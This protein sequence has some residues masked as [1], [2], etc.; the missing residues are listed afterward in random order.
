MLQVF[1]REGQS[2]ARQLRSDGFPVTSF[3]G[4]GRDG[5]IDMLFIEIPRKKARDI[6]LLVREI[7]PKSFY[8][9]ADVR[10]KPLPYVA[11]QQAPQHK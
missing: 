9:V 5:P 11:F 2:I 10:D 4:E 8:T 1:T 3:L 6:T 7:D